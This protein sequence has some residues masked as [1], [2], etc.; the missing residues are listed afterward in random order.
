M[1]MR[2]SFKLDLFKLIALLLLCFVAVYYLPPLYN[3]IY[4]LALLLLFWRS[5]NNYL[6]FAL[7]FILVS[8]PGGLFS[9]DL[10]EIIHR[11]PMYTVYSSISFSFFDL[12]LI[13]ALL[14][15]IYKGR[16]TQLL[17]KRSLFILM[18]YGVL[19]LMFSF[20]SGM[21]FGVL[22][23]FSRN[24]TFYT[25]FISIPYLVNKKE[26]YYRL[27]H[28]VFPVIFIIIFSQLFEFINGQELVVFLDPSRK[29]QILFFHEEVRP[30]TE[31]YL[32]NFF[33]FIFSMF[34]LSKSAYSGNRSYLIILITLSF[35]SVILSGTRAWI[36]M[37]IVFLFLYYTTIEKMQLRKLL[38]SSLIIL[39]VISIY[40]ISNTFQT[41]VDNSIERFLTIKYLMAGDITAGGT[42]LKISGRLPHVLE[43]FQQSP[44]IGLGF[45]N[46]FEK[47]SDDHVGNF[48]LLLQAGIVG[49]LFFIGFWINYYLMIFNTLK[50]I[51]YFHPYRKPLLV[52]ALAMS[53]MLLLHFT[54]FPFFRY[55]LQGFN[56]TFV[57]L[58][59]VISE[60]M[61]R[62]AIRSYPTIKNDKS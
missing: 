28:F 29:E 5:K 62:E 18:A 15:A 9:G 14:K 8:E 51:S 54:T 41:A 46:N 45:S 13:I 59:L 4:F 17:L 34:Y 50:K 33:V 55:A 49:F 23:T 35:V 2:N 3:K 36:F 42:F 27:I 60:F 43:G 37:F 48:N 53:C 21:D 12:F 52:L 40:F 58:F 38:L 19:L 24:V 39:A 32:L 44:I 20:V 16:R 61:V 47:Y 26:E 10:K 1:Q 56:S 30:Y 57:V 25:L 22:I 6:W 31:G 7:F 11:I